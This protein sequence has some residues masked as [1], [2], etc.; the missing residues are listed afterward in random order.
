MEKRYNFSRFEEKKVEKIEEPRVEPGVAR[1]NRG[2]LRISLSNVMLYFIICITLVT[3]LISYMH[4]TEVSAEVN[5]YEIELKNLQNEKS[6][7][8]NKLEKM[9]SL[10]VVEDFA[11][12]QLGMVQVQQTQLEYMTHNNQDKVEIIREQSVLTSLY[13]AISKTFNTVLEYIR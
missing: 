13:T 1:I 10:K 8:Q 9:T 5:Q 11:K 2:S 4:L 7:W 6:T 12:N 3:I